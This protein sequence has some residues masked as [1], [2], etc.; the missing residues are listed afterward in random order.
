MW[1][2]SLL[3]VLAPL[4]AGDRT[5]SEDILKKELQQFQGSWKAVSI[6]HGNGRQASED[7]VQ[8]T[9]LVV[10]ENKFTLTGKNYT[11]EGSFKVNPATAP[12]SI[13]VLLTSKDGRE[14]K[15]LGIY[16]TKGKTRKS[17]FA[18][19]EKE[20]PTQFSTEKGYFG[21]KWKRN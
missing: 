10:K 21:F 18:L 7:E 11:I 14:T 20:R 1:C 16:E 8:N 9:R 15:F 13:D 12:K 3:I 2:C 5:S 19:P 6:R 17:C 4:A